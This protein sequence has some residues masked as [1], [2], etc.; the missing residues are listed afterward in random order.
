MVVSGALDPGGLSVGTEADGKVSSPGHP[1]LK[2]RLEK[3][4]TD[5]STW[6]KRPVGIN[7]VSVLEA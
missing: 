4:R 2:I 6:A 7:T 3:G 5:S 1:P